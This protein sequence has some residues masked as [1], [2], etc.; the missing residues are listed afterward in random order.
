[1]WTRRD[2][3]VS[4]AGGV[5][6]LACPQWVQAQDKATGFTLPKLPYA[7]D[8]LEPY[9]DAETMMIHH[10]KHHQAYIDKL[11]AALAQAAPDWLNKPIEEIVAN[12]K[13][14]P[15]SVQGAARNQGGGHYNHSLFWTMMTKPGTGKSPSGELLKA[16]TTSFGDVAGLQKELLAKATGQFGSGWAWLVRGKDKPLAVV[17]SANQ[18]NP[19]TDGMHPLLGVD[20]WEHAYYLKYRN[21]RPAYVEAWFN[22]IHWDRVAELY[23][24]AGK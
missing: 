15:E 24:L 8:A 11:N 16:I 10:T 17:S 2:W 3:M 1:M 13:S 12:Y 4:A 22:L 23:A 21:Q 18:D 20:V 19:L 7:Y 6:A 14:L 9:I 5:A